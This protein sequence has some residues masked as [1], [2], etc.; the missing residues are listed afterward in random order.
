[1]TPKARTNWNRATLNKSQ[2]ACERPDLHI[3]YLSIR[4]ISYIFIMFIPTRSWVSH[5]MQNLLKPKPNMTMKLTSLVI[6][7]TLLLGET[8]VFAGHKPVRPA[9]AQYMQIVQTKTPKAVDPLDSLRSPV[10]PTDNDYGN[11][12]RW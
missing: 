5:R 8:A 2:G 4:Y 10:G 6:A 7:A 12:P 3:I 9:H 11:E 1:L